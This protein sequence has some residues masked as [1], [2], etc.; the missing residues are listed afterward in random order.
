MVFNDKAKIIGRTSQ[1]GSKKQGLPSSIG[2]SGALSRRMSFRSNLVINTVP[3]PVPAPDYPDYPA[4]PVDPVDPGTECFYQLES[5]TTF[6][7]V[8]DMGSRRD[9]NITKSGGACSTDIEVRIPETSKFTGGNSG[10]YENPP[11][12]DHLNNGFYLL[13]LSTE[14]VDSSNVTISHNG[15]TSWIIDGSNNKELYYDQG[16]IDLTFDFTANLMDSHPLLV[17][18][19][20]G[21]ILNIDNETTTQR[22]FRL[23]PLG[24]PYNYYCTAHGAMNGDIIVKDDSE[25]IVAKGLFTSVGAPDGGGFYEMKVDFKSIADFGVVDDDTPTYT[26]DGSKTFKIVEK[27][28]TSSDH[29]DGGIPAVFTSVKFPLPPT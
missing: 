19:A 5:V 3:V 12:T 6:G 26:F 13:D 21:N 4:D 11:F 14:T 16:P 25:N 8:G 18:D 23:D 2:R 9:L 20:C 15:I 10:Y 1:G 24:S 29:F 7:G 27:T 28:G 17:T 22:T